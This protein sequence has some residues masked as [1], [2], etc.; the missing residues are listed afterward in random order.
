MAGME[1][2][3]QSEFRHRRGRPPVDA[4]VSWLS[5]DGGVSPFALKRARV[6]ATRPPGGPGCSWLVDVQPAF[7]PTALAEYWLRHCIEFIVYTTAGDD[8][9]LVDAIVIDERSGMPRSLE[10]TSGWFRR[11]RTTLDVD[12]IVGILPI[13][14]RLVASPEGQNPLPRSRS[15]A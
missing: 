14:R 13:H 9:G 10:I 2:R 3:F 4:L 8:L 5:S 7:D 1:I 15:T 11:R 12:Q 6:D